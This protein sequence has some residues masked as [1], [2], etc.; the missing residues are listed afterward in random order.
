[1]HRVIDSRSIAHLITWNRAVDP[2]TELRN[3]SG[4]ILNRNPYTSRAVVLHLMKSLAAST[5][6]D[7]R[8]MTVFS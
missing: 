5:A 2:L 7:K 4:Q 6:C 1:M 8:E 3:G